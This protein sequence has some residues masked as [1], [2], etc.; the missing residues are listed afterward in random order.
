MLNFLKKSILLRVLFLLSAA[1]TLVSTVSIL[2]FNISNTRLL[3]SYQQNSIAN[4]SRFAAL[5]YANP[6]WDL[7]SQ[8]INSIHAAVLQDPMVLAVNLFSDQKFHSGLQKKMS[9][10]VMQTVRL[11]EPFVIGKRSELKRVSG[12]ISYETLPVGQFEIIYSD[13]IIREAIKTGTLRILLS[14]TIMAVAIIAI[15]FVGFNQATIKPVVRLAKLSREVALSQDFS[16]RVGK[17]GDDEIGQ[18]YD[19][20]NTM[21]AQIHQRER[22]R[23]MA[24]EELSHARN[25]L[26]NVINSMP[27]ML[28]SINMDGMITQWNEAAANI[29]GI[30]AMK[31][32]GR[33]LWQIVP[34]LQKYRNLQQEIIQD[35]RKKEFYRESFI[36]DDGKL[37]NIIFFP[38]IA[39]GTDGMVIRLDDITELEEKEAQLRHAQKMESIGTLAGGLAHDFNNM[40]GAI[41]GSLSMLRMKIAKYNRLQPQELDYF[42]SLMESACIR[43]SEMVDHLLSL[44]RKKSMQMTTVDLN[45]SIRQVMNLCENTF[46]KSIRLTPHY[47]GEEAL[48][49]G[50]PTQLEQVLL[51]LCINSAHAL[52]IMKS[53]EE[54]Q[55]GL[56]SIDLEKIKCDTHFLHTHSEAQPGEYWKLSVM[57]T[58]VGMDKRT[59]AK[60][61]DPFFT[62]KEK[63]KGTGL[64]L[65]VV[66]NIIKQHLGFIDLYTEEGVGTTFNIYLPISADRMKGAMPDNSRVSPKG[67]GLI[68]VVDDEPMMREVAE[69]ILKENGYEVLLAQDGEEGVDLFLKHQGRIRGVLL[70]LAMPKKSG[71]EA[72]Q[73]MKRIDPN[74]RVLLASGFKKDERIRFLL[75]SGVHSFIEKPYTYE[76]LTTAIAQMLGTD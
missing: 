72:F 69:A 21:L 1:V 18:L 40:L 3:E 34:K 44:G 64:G 41:A 56:L 71:R 61:F 45:Q 60:V 57:D 55:G 27:S 52:T 16:L 67:S 28:I 31:A 20:F 19:G 10:G 75:N 30:P 68:L 33:S 49:H 53:I 36:E 6:L 12:N 25:L 13:R 37:Y 14:F 32:V 76:K 4:V 48:V 50:D 38:L 24:T 39:N 42:L 11:V 59:A 8:G 17:K 23:D 22:E 74:V 70:D 5:G 63:G 51:N 54:E 29:T 43:A 58:G 65:A 9:E 35:K 2:Y 26:H 46:D 47:R 66:Y 62:T 7:N 73:E 15:V